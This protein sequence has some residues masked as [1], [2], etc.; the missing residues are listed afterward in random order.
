MLYIWPFY[1]YDYSSKNNLHNEKNSIGLLVSGYSEP[2]S[3]DEYQR[4]YNEFYN[5]P[6][7]K[8]TEKD[9]WFLFKRN[10]VRIDYLDIFDKKQ[11]VYYLDNLPVSEERGKKIT[12]Q[13]RKKESL[14]PLDVTLEGIKKMCGK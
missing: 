12:K 1:Q 4:V 5:D 11:T 13:L 10:L 9:R 8:D 3:S 2:E 14:N 7:F 6:E